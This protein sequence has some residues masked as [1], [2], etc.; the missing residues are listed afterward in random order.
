[1]AGDDSATRQSHH[2]RDNVDVPEIAE[3]QVRI[4][5]EARIN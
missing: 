5:V 2:L 1:M 4:T 3:G